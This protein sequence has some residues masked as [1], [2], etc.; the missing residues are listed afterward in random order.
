MKIFI[1]ILFSV[2]F[3]RTAT[4]LSFEFPDSI[5]IHDPGLCAGYTNMV[6]CGPGEYLPVGL[7]TCAPCHERCGPLRYLPYT[8]NACLLCPTSEWTTA[9]GYDIPGTRAFYC[10]GGCFSRNTFASRGLSE[11]PLGFPNLDDPK[12]GDKCYT[13]FRFCPGKDAKFLTL[14]PATSDDDCVKGIMYSKASSDM[15]E[16]VSNLTGD[17]PTVGHYLRGN[18]INGDDKPYKQDYVFKNWVIG[19]ESVTASTN[20]MSSTDKPASLTSDKRL[21]AVWGYWVQYFGA[22]GTSSVTVSALSGEAH[23]LREPTAFTNN[24]SFK[25]DG[26]VFEGWCSE[27]PGSN[28]CPVLSFLHPGDKICDTD[29]CGSGVKQITHQDGVYKLYAQYHECNS[30]AGDNFV[31]DDNNNCVCAKGYYGSETAGCT[32]CDNG[33]TTEDIGTTS[34][35]GCKHFFRYKVGD[36]YEAWTWPDSVTPGLVSLP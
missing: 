25:K 13:E 11:C 32:K 8:G 31:V 23:T 33:M 29:N 30:A 12:D 1:S 6:F 17:V 3:I 16:Y 10:E 18:F 21:Y 7:N 20:I 28:P 5:I 14:N 24:S 26:A 15:F 2:F 36:Y 19:E 34:S 35:D 4:A 27:N 22:D 9:C